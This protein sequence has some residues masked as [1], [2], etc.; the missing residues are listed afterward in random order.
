[1]AL[2][3]RKNHNRISEFLTYI[4]R[5]ND[6]HFSLARETG[7]PRVTLCRIIDGSVCPDFLTVAIITEAIERRLGKR[8]DPRELVAFNGEYLTPDLDELLCDT[9]EDAANA[10]SLPSNS[11]ANQARG[12][13]FDPFEG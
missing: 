8:L 1:M 11:W 10:A 5:S 2:V 7:L 3:N 12:L 4:D 6:A 9:K 13:V